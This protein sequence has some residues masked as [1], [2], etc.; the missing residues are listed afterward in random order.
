MV[1]LPLFVVKKC[2]TASSKLGAGSNRLGIQKNFINK[3]YDTIEIGIGK[4]VDADLARESAVLQSLQVK[5][6]LGLQ[7]L[8]VANFTPS[9]VLRLFPART[10]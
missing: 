6:Q 5:Q 1:Q 3:L 7:A 2:A 10:A 4:L 8:S 9:A